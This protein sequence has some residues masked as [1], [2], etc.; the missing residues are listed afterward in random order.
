M[1]SETVDDDRLISHARLLLTNRGR[2][3]VGLVHE[4]RWDNGKGYGV[5]TGC[6]DRT[7]VACGEV[8]IGDSVRY[9]LRRYIVRGH[10]A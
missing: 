5:T 4:S 8:R 7:T 2:L 10:D 9:R 1:S 6:A 3:P